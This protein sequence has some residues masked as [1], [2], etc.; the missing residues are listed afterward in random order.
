MDEEEFVNDTIKGQVEPYLLSERYASLLTVSPWYA[1][2]LL[3]AD[4]PYCPD[5]SSELIKRKTK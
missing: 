5:F 1:R 4:N 3:S 2:E